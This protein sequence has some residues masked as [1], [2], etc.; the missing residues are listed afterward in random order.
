M[1]KFDQVMED[2][3]AK[4]PRKEISSG[5]SGAGRYGKNVISWDFFKAYW[6]FCIFFF[7]IQDLSYLHLT[8]EK[9]MNALLLSYGLVSFFQTQGN[10]ERN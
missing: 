1:S 4:R 10:V 9:R 7:S 8:H 3:S 6:Q 2:M 5:L